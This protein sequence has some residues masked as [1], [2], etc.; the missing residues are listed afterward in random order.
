MES[1]TQESTLQEYNDK[2]ALTEKPATG[3][4]IGGGLSIGPRGNALDPIRKSPTT[5]DEQARIGDWVLQSNGSWKLVPNSETWINANRYAVYGAQP[6]QN[7]GFSE[8]M[9]AVGQGVG[10]G[11]FAGSQLGK[12]VGTGVGVI[13]FIGSLAGAEDQYLK[14]YLNQ[15][16]TYEDVLEEDVDE[17]GSKIYRI[18][19]DKIAGAGHGSGQIV[20]D[21]MDTTSTKAMLTGDN[22]LSINV[23]PAF[24]ASE[25]YRNV[26]DRI[27]ELTPSLT[28][29]QANTVVD[30]ETGKTT[31]DMINDVVKDEELQFYYN[32]QTAV[33]LKKVAPTASDE[34][35]AEAADTQLIGVLNEKTLE[36][37]EVTVYGNDNTKHTVNAKQYLDGIKDMNEEQR[38][39]YMSSIGNRI[40]SDGI[41][42]DEKAVLQAQ[43]N[44]LYSA[45]DNDG[46][47]HDMYKK[48]F[49]DTIADSRTLIFGIR[50]GSVLPFLG[51]QELTTFKENDFWGPV[52]NTVSTIGRYF[53]MSKASNGI[54]GL[55]RKGVAALGTK[56]SGPVGEFLTKINTFA[57][58]DAPSPFSSV[59]KGQMGLG[60]WA[61]RTATQTTMMAGADLAYETARAAAYGI[62]GEDF[63]FWGEL[64]QDLWMDAIMTY[65]PRNYAQAVN[66]P[67][68]EYRRYDGDATRKYE[69]DQKI[70]EK[71]DEIYANNIKDLA[72]D[73]FD[74]GDLYPTGTGIRQYAGLVEVTAKELAA[75]HAKR[76]DNLTGNKIA[77]RVQEIIADKNAAMAKLAVQVKAHDGPDELYRRMLRYGNDIRRVTAEETNQFKQFGTVAKDMQTM[78]DKMKDLLP[79]KQKDFSKEDINYINASANRHRFLAENKGNKEAEDYIHKHYDKYIDGM[80]QDRAAQLEEYMTA[81]RKVVG[82]V[83]DFY[84]AKGLMSDAEIKKLRNSP[85]YK[86]GM[87]LPVFSKNDIKREGDI[88]QSRRKL[89]KVFNKDE[90]IAVEDLDHPLVSFSQYINNAMRNIAINDRALAIR[91]AAA[92]VGVGIHTFADTGESLK[93]TELLKEMNS[94][95]A[96]RYDNIVK[97]V[98]KE[99]P[100]HQ[101]WQKINDELVLES[102][103]LKHSET[104]KEVKNETTK[105]RRKLTRLVKAQDAALKADGIVDADEIRGKI[106][107]LEKR[108]EELQ[109][110]K[111]RITDDYEGWQKAEDEINRIN[112]EVEGLKSELSDVIL[113]GRAKAELLPDN[114]DLDTV[115]V[116]DERVDK[117]LKN[118]KRKVNTAEEMVDRFGSSVREFD[119]GDFNWT[120]DGKTR[121]AVQNALKAS[122]DAGV[123]EPLLRNWDSERAARHDWL[124]IEGHVDRAA[125]AAIDASDT[126]LSTEELKKI[127]DDALK[128]AILNN[129]SEDEIA[130]VPKYANAERLAERKEILRLRNEKLKNFE[131]IKP[132]IRDLGISSYAKVYEGTIP[133]GGGAYG[134]Y[135]PNGASYGKPYDEIDD[136]RLVAKDGSVRRFNTD[137]Q[138]IRLSL[139]EFDKALNER[140]YAL[141]DLKSTLMHEYAHAAFDKAVNR[142]PIL[143][144]LLHMLGIDVK[145]SEKVANSRSATEL[146]AYVTQKKFLDDI[147]ASEFSERF[148]DDRV[149]QRYL[150]GI[151]KNIGDDT[152]ANFKE[153]FLNML[154]LSVDFVKAK[155]LRLTDVKTF[156]EFYNGLVNGNFKDEMRLSTKNRPSSIE[157]TVYSPDLRAY[158]READDYVKDAWMKERTLGTDFMLDKVNLAALKMAEDIQRIQDQI[159]ANIVKQGELEDQI[160]EAARK[161]IEKA[162][163][164]AKGSPVDLDV[165][166]F[167]NVELTNALKEALKSNNPGGQIQAVL[168]SAVEKANPYISRNSIIQAR[169]AEAA[170]K[171]RKRVNKH[172]AYKA[173]VAKGKKM[174]QESIN[175]LADKVYDKVMEKVVGRKNQVSAI[176]DAELT[177]ILNSDDPHTIRY[178]LDGKEQRLVL[179][180]TGSEQL[181]REFK[182]PETVVSGPI[183]E[184][185]LNKGRALAQAKRYLTTSADPSRVLPNLLRDWSRGIVTTGGDILLSPDDLRTDALRYWEGNDKAA[186][187][188]NDGYE[189]VNA[190]VAGDTLTQ[191][192]MMPRK[193]RGKSMV[194]AM[195]SEDGN[196]YTRFQ[197]KT[198][199]E[200]LSILQDTAE[201]FTRKRAMEVAYY[202]TLADASARGVDINKAVEMAVEAGYFA[203]REA[204]TNFFRRG[205]LITKIAQMV[206]YLS[207]KFASL[208]SFKYSYLDN[209]IAVGRSLKV[210]V[211][212]YSAL[213]ALALSNEESRKKYYMLTEYDRANNIIIPLTNDMIMTI[214][215][216]ETMAAFL[217]PYRRA[218]ETL[219]GVDPVAFY[220]WGAE[221]LEALS[222]LDLTGFSEGDKFNV[223]RGLQKIGSQVIPTWALPFLESMT[224]TDWFYGSKISVDEEYVGART[225]NYSPTAGE[226]TTKSANSKLLAAVADGTGIPQWILQEF[227]GEYGGNVGQYALNAIDKLSGATEAAQG[228]KEFF[229]SIFKPLTGADSDAATQAFWN[230]VDILEEKKKKLQNEIRTLNGDI[231]SSAGDKKAELQQKR[232]EKISQYGTDIT[233]FLNQYL[234]AYEITGGLT[235]QQAN[236]IWRLYLIYDQDGNDKLYAEGTVEEYYA[237]KAESAAEKK[238]TNLAAQSGLDQY[239][240]SHNGL[241]DYDTSYAMR[242]LQNTIYG[243]P[244]KQMVEIANILE[245][246]SDYDNSFKKL[247]QDARNARSKAYDVKNYD[248]ADKIAYE[249]D[250]KILSAL[251]PY[252]LKNGIAETLNRSAVINYLQEWIMVPSSEMRTSKGKY[253][254]NLGVDAQK[255]KAFVKQFVKKMY[256]VSGE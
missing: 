165:E 229:D 70:I 145:V 133:G 94:E 181:V 158:N 210:T 150:D 166:T 182:A 251:F 205:E 238:A 9:N 52:I 242:A 199:G 112:Q 125:T 19:Y 188:I 76:I 4:G 216:D 84:K 192:M 79:N 160:K 155:L 24:A 203:G 232:Q 224:G 71:A 135:S 41:S 186:K 42:D 92:V 131:A 27:K 222:P 16:I 78:V 139:T 243:V 177:R 175:A 252:L 66:M 168:N 123:K 244:T 195:R 96:K 239:Y 194:R 235:K 6:K 23:S 163:E 22:S 51:S 179:T 143:T 21:A 97:K 209:P 110:S 15:K 164:Y 237:D 180:G 245:D 153:R 250:Y 114:E 44:A 176:N 213:I 75:R 236:R 122:Y 49:I 25:R 53:A 161:T 172:M 72:E 240:V 183:R 13:S 50:V 221:F 28:V 83:L 48:D 90:L 95:F 196:A 98:K 132:L 211:T 234:Q 26:I 256:G 130:S 34:A 65:G 74:T 87:F 231:A 33:D 151:L 190:G 43:A 8:F 253:V 142:V 254:P 14:D 88:S 18:N 247:R 187:I 20:K 202:K 156:A 64:G 35:L 228:G 68:Y 5:T 73:E 46:S 137:G 198:T 219:N 173:N 29:D 77:I 154:Q 63:D 207:Q 104:L 116:K 62:T 61:A 106:R 246:T 249:Y 111:P 107:E 86:N 11:L 149:A 201:E 127:A 138:T 56:I 60:A 147:G 81:M 113:S 167:V 59:A 223:I 193:N 120:I 55:M 191:S 140:P 171:F 69:S 178:M 7:I 121:K 214:P 129:L 170:E 255:E 32:A 212:T 189:L 45:S 17:D 227:L 82:Q 148:K 162:Q 109:N 38:N 217:T 124:L 144:D 54:E 146:V 226:L 1:E 185:L 67:K 2:K 103:V 174:S 118:L 36:S 248:L 218:I 215:L 200:K 40:M 136:N 91:D 220:V 128:E 30:E 31:L 102:D 37:T 105:L 39:D 134:V 225:G 119:D 126:A 47:Y 204:T 184:W 89:N 141:E 12:T 230:G 99:Y 10:M 58:Q 208:E 157:E 85:A 108:S 233:D 115:L 117:E 101:K 80:D 152:P 57:P 206:P 241:T 93:E 3:T 159:D 197:A 100:S 169:T